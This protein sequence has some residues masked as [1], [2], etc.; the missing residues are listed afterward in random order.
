VNSKH[1]MDAKSVYVN[2]PHGWA[3]LVVSEDGVV[4]CAWPLPERVYAEDLPGTVKEEY[5]SSQAAE[6]LLAYFNGRF[7]LIVKVPLDSRKLTQWQ[8]KTYKLVRSI[9]PGETLSYGSVAAKCGSRY[10]AQAVG[11]A[12]A[13]N[14]VPLFVPCH[15]VIYG[16]GRIGSYSCGGTALKKWLL[17]WEKGAKAGEVNSV[18][19]CSIQF[20][21]LK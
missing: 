13:S 18:P 6:A 15:R 2:T 21:F 14:P 7:D 4:E 5:L 10:A 16:D 9:P 17:A 19:T 1:K 3:H 12:M 8:R 11:Q 20:S